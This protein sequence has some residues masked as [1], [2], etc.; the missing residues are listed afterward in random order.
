MTE[1]PRQPHDVVLE[2]LTSEFWSGGLGLTLVT[3]SLVLLIFI[4]MPLQRAGLPERM[5]LDLLIVTLMIFGAAAVDQSRV[6]TASTVVILFATAVVLGTARFYPTFLL[7]Q[8]GS[9]LTTVALFL[10]IRIVLLVMFRRGQITWTRIQGGICAY[11]LI[12][13]VWGSAYE[14]LERMHPGSFSFVTAAADI[15]E[16]SAK[17]TYFSFSTLTTV[18]FGD[19]TPVL[20]FARSL[21]IAE[22]IVGQLFPAILIGALV[23]MAMQ[24]RHKSDDAHGPG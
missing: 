16:L 10:Y 19:V 3:V 20:P 7:N 22:A 24:P 17:L 8:L 21:A 18:G 11:L 12:G 23:A 9:L 5:F 1:R 6:V 14:F 13:L 2:G 15:D 4:V